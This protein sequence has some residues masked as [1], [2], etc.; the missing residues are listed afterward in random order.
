VRAGASTDARIYVT[1]RLRRGEVVRVVEELPNGWL[2]IVPP[3]GSFSWI[4]TRFV[5]RINPATP[6]NWAVHAP[7]EVGIPVF[8]GSEFVNGRPTI[9]GCKVLFGAILISVG[10]PVTDD[11]GS[12][13]P[14]Q[15]P[16]A[17]VRYIRADA[18]TRTSASPSPSSP[19]AASRPGFGS[20]SLS[21]PGP[22]ATP[23]SLWARAQQAE[24][25]GKE[26]EAEQLYTQAADLARQSNPELAEQAAE[27]ARWLHEARSNPTATRQPAYPTGDPGRFS[28]IPTHAATET[29][30]V[31]LAPPCGNA[32]PGAVAAAPASARPMQSS[33]GGIYASGPGRLRR[34]GRAMDNR[35]TYVLEAAPGRLPLYVTPQ[36]G[37]DLEPYLN[38]KVELFGPAV[39][40]GDLRANYMAVSRVQPL[41]E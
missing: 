7:A 5:E 16:V 23:E 17:E 19:E 20:P 6:N 32:A 9:E 13:L 26:G 22:A 35:P 15:P 18:V 38:R 14:V 30:I 11:A 1:N 27:R 3:P 28:P 8:V 37:I 39:Y 29:P 31:R 34:A 24:R 25:A 40:N 41:P 21:V 33:A 2:K 10:K 4:N 36:R 12:W